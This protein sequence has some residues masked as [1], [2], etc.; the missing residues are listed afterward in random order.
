VDGKCFLTTA[1][2]LSTEGSGEADFRSAISRAYYACFLAARHIAF[3]NCKETYRQTFKITREKDITHWGLQ[4]HL[5]GGL[6][7]PVRQLGED[8]AALHGSRKDA[9]YEMAGCPFGA[10]DATHSIEEAG[11][12]LAALAEVKPRDIGNAMEK[13]IQF[14][15][16]MGGGA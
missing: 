16:R 8:L 12:F 5:K 6:I 15:R 10:K 9:D 11:L 4:Q 2:F 1:Q 7:E 14:P 13:Q 3:I